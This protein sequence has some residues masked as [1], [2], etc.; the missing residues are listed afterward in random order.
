MPC[1]LRGQTHPRPA[2]RERQRRS[3]SPLARG[4]RTLRDSTGRWDWPMDPA[5]PRSRGEHQRAPRLRR[6]FHGSSPLARGAHLGTR[7]SL[8]HPR[9]IPTRTEN[10]PSPKRKASSHSAH[11]RS[12][13]EHLRRLFSQSISSGS[14]L[15]M[16]GNTQHVWCLCLGLRAHPRSRGEHGR[17]VAA[18]GAM[19]GSSPLV[20]GAPLPSP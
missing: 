15:L 4:A 13:R 9:L 18:M 1:R 8:R 3:S 7:R 11:P 17:A 20:R 10:T 16:R 6:P 19:L 14:S 12:R 2:R 5:H